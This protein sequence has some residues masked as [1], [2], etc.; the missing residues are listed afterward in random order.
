[1][2]DSTAT[3]V[4]PESSHFLRANLKPPSI[5]ARPC[6]HFVRIGTRSPLGLRL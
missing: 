4:R 5:A 3:T 6:D 1:M 2:P